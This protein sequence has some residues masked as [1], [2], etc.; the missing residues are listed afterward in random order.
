[1]KW[2]L[3]KTKW[4]RNSKTKSY[5]EIKTY[6]KKITVSSCQHFQNKDNAFNKKQKIIWINIDYLPILCIEMLSSKTVKIRNQVCTISNFL[7]H[8]FI[9]IF[10]ILCSNSKTYFCKI[11]L[12]T[13]TRANSFFIDRDC[14]KW[15]IHAHLTNIPP[16]VIVFICAFIA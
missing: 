4:K 10:W 5:H 12:S 7:I 6:L 3:L 2:G 9:L 13:N 16:Q 8:E 14:I 15:C 11:M 1:M